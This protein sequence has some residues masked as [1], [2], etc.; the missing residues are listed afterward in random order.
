M[1]VDPVMLIMWVKWVSIVHAVNMPNLI[2]AFHL[3]HSH[4]NGWLI[5]MIGKLSKSSFSHSVLT[6]IIISWMNDGIYRSYPP[7][8]HIGKQYRTTCKGAFI[9]LCHCWLSTQHSAK[10]W[11][12]EISTKKKSLGTYFARPRDVGVR[13]WVCNRALQ[14]SQSGWW[15]GFVCWHWL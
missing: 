6:L 11:W 12:Y 8:K 14:G 15:D 13:W 10:W 7:T 5:W 4:H 3:L 1:F 9:T 2:S